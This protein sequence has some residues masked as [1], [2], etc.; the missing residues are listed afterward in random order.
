VAESVVEALLA[1]EG[2]SIAGTR[3]LLPRAEKARDVLPQEL[4]AAGARVDVVAAYR[5]APAEGRRD[6]LLARLA[7]GSIDCITFASTS[8]VENFFALIDPALVR[9]RPDVLLAA[10]GPV[11]AKAVSGF[12]LACGLIPDRYTIPA[13][14]EAVR[15]RFAG[16]AHPSRDCPPQRG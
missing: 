13:L 12:G 7:E 4:A 3:I 1:R 10:I 8:T 2:S 11:T 9:D 15:D 6:A 14:V 16:M 5:T